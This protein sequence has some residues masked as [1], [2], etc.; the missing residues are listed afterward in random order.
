MVIQIWMQ[1]LSER[2]G[3]GNL[4][5]QTVLERDS[6]PKLILRLRGQSDRANFALVQNK[7]K[8]YGESAPPRPK[9]RQELLLRREQLRLNNLLPSRRRVGLL[10]L[11]LDGNAYNLNLNLPDVHNQLP[12]VV[13]LGYANL[14]AVSVQ[15]RVKLIHLLVKLNCGNHY[16]N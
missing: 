9:T 2:Q 16:A 3:T 4:I 6:A 7:D 13:K 12:L 15:I 14:C 8:P 10:H 1:Q 11:E 5:L